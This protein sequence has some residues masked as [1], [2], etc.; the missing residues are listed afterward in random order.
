MNDDSINELL[1]KLIVVRSYVILRSEANQFLVVSQCQ[2][3]TGSGT[4][5][6]RQ[7]SY[8]CVVA[9]DWLAGQISCLHFH[10]MSSFLLYS[11]CPCV[12]LG[13]SATR[14]HLRSAM[15][16]IFC[17]LNFLDTCHRAPLND[18]ATTWP[19]GQATQG[20]CLHNVQVVTGTR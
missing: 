7:E 18:S 17:S 5:G 16:F 14:Q 1:P 9:A 19:P 12:Q 13:D 8:R 2:K 20:K 15:V 10:Q 11:S 4:H 3:R 6:Q